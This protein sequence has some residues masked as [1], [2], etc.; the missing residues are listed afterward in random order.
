MSPTIK[1]KTPG[2]KLIPSNNSK[3]QF[4]TIQF[5]IVLFDPKTGRTSDAHGSITT[6]QGICFPAPKG[7]VQSG[8]CQ[9][10]VPNSNMAIISTLVFVCGM[11]LG[12]DKRK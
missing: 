7:I 8:V 1:S 11:W 9:I 10:D 6:L 2:P 12:V 3:F 5:T 4:W